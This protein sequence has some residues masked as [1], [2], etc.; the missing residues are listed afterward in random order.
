MIHQIFKDIIFAY[1]FR[2]WREAANDNF[3]MRINS[4]TKEYLQHDHRNNNIKMIILNQLNESFKKRCI[5]NDKLN[6]DSVHSLTLNL[7]S[8]LII[9]YYLININHHQ[10]WKAKIQF[11]K[12]CD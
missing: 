7:I 2:M 8:L 5:K 4:Q 6:I 12:T 9:D 3:K 10:E 11:K 1:S